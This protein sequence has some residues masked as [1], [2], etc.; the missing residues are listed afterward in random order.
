MMTE[1]VRRILQKGGNFEEIEEAG[2]E[3][4]EQ[5]AMVKTVKKRGERWRKINLWPQ[6]IGLD[7]RSWGEMSDSM[8]FEKWSHRLGFW[9]LAAEA[10]FGWGI[11]QID[12]CLVFK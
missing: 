8:Q 5:E 2:N 12:V 4:Q 1:R 7:P 9:H 11:V 10:Y 6:T 3:G